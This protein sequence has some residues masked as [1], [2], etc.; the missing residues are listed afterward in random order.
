MKKTNNKLKHNPEHLV[1]TMD[2]LYEAGMMTKKEY[3]EWITA[4]DEVGWDKLGE[5]NK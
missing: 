2:E 5:N 4:R 3:D 1:K